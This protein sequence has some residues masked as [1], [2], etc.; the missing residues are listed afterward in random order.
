MGGAG[1]V[2]AH[3]A[4]FSN[5]VTLTTVL[6]NDKLGKLAKR[7]LKKYKVKLNPIYEYD[8]PTTE[9]SIYISKNHNLLKV[10]TLSNHPITNNNTYLLEN[11]YNIQI[12]F[13]KWMSFGLPFSILLISSPP[14]GPCSVEIMTSLSMYKP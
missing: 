11:E 5:N 9:K 7:M 4:S 10:N 14:L 6:N 2:A 13:V 12:S 3:F 1:I 8:R